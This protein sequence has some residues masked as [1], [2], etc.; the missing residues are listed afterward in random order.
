MGDSPLTMN[1]FSDTSDQSDN[2]PSYYVTTINQSEENDFYP[3]NYECEEKT[4]FY[5]QQKMKKKA[6]TIARER[7]M[8]YVSLTGK[9]HKAKNAKNGLLCTENCRLKCN[10]NFS[11]EDR[12]TILNFYYNL[13]INDKNRLLFNNMSMHKPYRARKDAQLHKQYS[14]K[15]FVPYNDK[16]IQVCKAALQSLYQISRR[17]IDIIQR[18][19]QSGTLAPSL[20][21]RGRHCNRPH[22]IKDEVKSYV[23]QHIESL[24]YECDDKNPLNMKQ[25]FDL[26]VGLCKNEKKSS[27]FFVKKSYYM[28]A[29]TS[30]KR[31]RNTDSSSN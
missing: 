19:L 18:K 8:A 5:N 31:V 4:V 20:D 15:Y 17:K 3:P 21:M 10:E 24:K 14:Y 9:E 25:M 11:Y 27:D 29:V 6:I 26:Y 28:N 16:N 1:I 2:S 22:K 30:T 7:G 12:V 23:V 13:D